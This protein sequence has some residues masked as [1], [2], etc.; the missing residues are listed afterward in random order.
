MATLLHDPSSIKHHDPIHGAKGREPVCNGNDRAVLAESP[1]RVLNQCFALTVQGAC[2][3][4]QNQNGRILDEGPRKCHPLT[5]AA[6]E[7]K[8]PLAHNCLEPL[9]SRGNERLAM[10]ICDGAP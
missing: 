4:I 2:G 5:L 1:E 10:G 3:L 8:A 6:R 9:G 7:P